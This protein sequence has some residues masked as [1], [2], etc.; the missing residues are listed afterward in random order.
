MPRQAGLG[1]GYSG[2]LQGKES[3][4]EKNLV[5]WGIFRGRPSLRKMDSHTDHY[6]LRYYVR[7]GGVS[8]GV[9][10]TVCGLY[11]RLCK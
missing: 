8:A 5:C 2:P 9:G 10:R 1:G 6:N 11:K 3:C 7:C 4:L